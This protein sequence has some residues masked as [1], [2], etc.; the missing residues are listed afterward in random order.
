MSLER[1][2]FRGKLDPAWHD[3]MRAVADA[4]HKSDGEWIE[5][6]IL[7]ELKQRVHVASVIAEAAQR[8][9]IAGNSREKPGRAG[10]DAA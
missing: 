1:K 6:L 4:E 10:K 8:A 5:E 2:D 3:L 9:G 7:R